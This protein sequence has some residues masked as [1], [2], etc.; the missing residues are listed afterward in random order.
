MI[1]IVMYDLKGAKG[2]YPEFFETLKAQGSWWHYLKAS[3]WLVSTEKSTQE[4]YDALRSHIR[5]GDH[6]LVWEL[7]RKRQG[8]LPRA[9]WD[10]IKRHESSS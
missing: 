3:A 4:V 6:L 5:D 9:A 8:W 2:S 10:W 1:H 7:G